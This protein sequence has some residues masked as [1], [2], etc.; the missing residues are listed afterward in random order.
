MDTA[1]QTQENTSNFTNTGNDSLASENLGETNTISPENQAL[2]ETSAENTLPEEPLTFAQIISSPSILE[3][4]DKLGFTVPT[5]VQSKTIP[6]AE[7]GKD[8]IIQ[9]QTGSGKTLAFLIPLLAKLENVEN[10]DAPFALIV[11]PTRELALQIE[12][13][14]RTL[15]STIQPT[16]LI[17]GV[18]SDKQIASIRQDARVVIGTPGR[19]L[20]LIKQKALKLKTCRYVVLDEADEMLSMGFLEDVRAILS[21]LPD[22]RQ[23]LFVSATITSRVDMLAHS[24]LSHPQKVIVDVP[25]TEAP[26]IDHF[27]G[28]VAGD[29]MAKPD[30]LCDIIETQ[31][32]TSAIIFCNT[33]SDTEFVEAILRRRGF[34]A[35]RINSDLTQSQRT[36]IMNKIRNEELQFLVATDI[37]ARGLDIDQIDLVVNYSIHEEPEAYVHRTGRTGRAGKY[38]RAISLVG[39]RDF[40]AFHYIK[41]MLEIDFKPMELPSDDEVCSARLAHLYEIIRNSH[42]EVKPRDNI[43]ARKLITEM[44]GEGEPSEELEEIAAKLCRFIIERHLKENNKSLDEELT[45]FSEVPT[46][47][48]REQRHERRDSY[49]RRD[50]RDNYRGRDNRRNDRRDERQGDR[51]SHDDRRTDQRSDRYSRDDRHDDRRNSHYDQRE[52]RPRRDDQQPTRNYDNRRDDRYHDR[53]QDRGRDHSQND[54]RQQ[55][56]RTRPAHYQPE[57]D[58]R[59]DLRQRPP[60]GQEVRLYIG[61]GTAQGMNEDLFRQLATTMGDVEQSDLRHVS[62]RDSYGFVDLTEPQASVLIANLDGIEYNGAVLPIQRAAVLGKSQQR[63]SKPQGNQE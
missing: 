32:P 58:G 52:S 36:K 57:Q 60:K 54:R 15:S 19:I 1:D 30:A 53:R 27:Y 12:S 55:P 24:F 33:K 3:I 21:R 31:R 48:P 37:A 43:L 63:P 49:D 28:D 51:R 46:R 7:S 4:I 17:G 6:A 26:L 61:Q 62:I 39:P 10:Q 47:P 14:L 50:N 11:S 18:D 45:D 25:N 40:G 5:P 38:G 16:C 23:M 34:D 35:R 22:E 41:K 59:T 8:L 2:D 42:L 13:V 20:D 9:A 29:I 56:D 44:G